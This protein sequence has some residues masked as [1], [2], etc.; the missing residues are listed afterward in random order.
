MTWHRLGR[1][2]MELGS[3]TKARQT[4]S[5]VLRLDKFNAIAAKN[6][7]LLAS[8][9]VSHSPLSA[10]SAPPPLF[11][12]EPGITKTV[13]LIRLGDPKTLAS[14][15]PGTPV[16]I[17]CRGHSV[18]TTSP[19]DQYLGRLPDDLSSRLR[20]FIRSGNQYSAWIKSVGP[21]FLK[22]F[23]KETVR[24][25]KYK[26]TPSFPITEKLTYAAFT[27]PELVHEEKPDVASTEE[28]TD[29]FSEPP[30]TPDERREIL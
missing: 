6:L 4:F 3:K 27:P 11:L 15:H 9:R 17:V 2:Y 19:T 12:E 18:S 25:S 8:S 1:A 29:S 22:V 16:H 23:I 28:D 30:D 5:Q 13:S 10:S 14:L 24:T 21:K 26:N 7:D 20:P